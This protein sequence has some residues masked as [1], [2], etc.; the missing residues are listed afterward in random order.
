M[1]GVLSCTDLKGKSVIGD[2][3]NLAVTVKPCVF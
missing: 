2:Y 1:E 3:V